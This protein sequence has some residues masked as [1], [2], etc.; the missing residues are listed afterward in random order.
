MRKELRNHTNE[1]STHYRSIEDKPP[2]GNTYRKPSGGSFDHQRRIAMIPDTKQR[3]PPA[4]CY[5]RNS[6]AV[7][8]YGNA[9]GTL[10]K[11]A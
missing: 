11:Q 1:L 4:Y 8:E 10:P 3:T 6:A 9:S 2:H 5:L 7:T